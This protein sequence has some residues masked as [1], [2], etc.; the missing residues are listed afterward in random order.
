MIEGSDYYDDFK[1]EMELENEGMV[2]LVWLRWTCL[3]LEAA[4]AAL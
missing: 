3:G 4:D 2:I 1:G